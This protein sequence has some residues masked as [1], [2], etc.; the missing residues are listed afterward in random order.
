MTIFKEKL[1]TLIPE[2]NKHTRFALST[3]YSVPMYGTT[4][5]QAKTNTSIM[6]SNSGIGTVPYQCH[7]G[8]FQEQIS[9][10]SN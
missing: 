3:D 8:R 6:P 4:K 9:S 5:R 10:K 7:F 1:L 2:P